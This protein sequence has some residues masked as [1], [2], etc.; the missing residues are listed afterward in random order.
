MVKG[1]VKKLK[2]RPLTID[3]KF[4]RVGLK[5]V[6][7]LTDKEP[8]CLVGGIATQSY[9][10]SSCR[11]PTSDID[12]SVVKPLNYEDFK[13]FSKPVIEY[14]KDNGYFVETRQR[15]RAFNLEVENKDGD[16]LLIEFSKRNK[17]SF[18]NSKKRLERELENSKRKRIENGEEIYVV[19]SPEDIVVPKL[20]RSINSL[21][22]N[23]KFNQLLPRKVGLSDRNISSR[24]EKI[25]KYREDAMLNPTDLEFAE[26]LRFISDIYDIEILSIVAGINLDYFKKSSKDWNVL[27]EDNFYKNVL[28]SLIPKINSD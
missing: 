10:P 24:L 20:V 17:K 18:D 16:K 2:V 13:T 9:I 26:S 1:E 21:N 3:D 12:F 19:S 27:N 11:R 8:Y 22:R 4:V 15:S 7:T 14:L 28:F 23:P 6:S 25:G 5:A